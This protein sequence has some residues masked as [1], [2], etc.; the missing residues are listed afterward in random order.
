MFA[1]LSYIGAHWAL[2][3]AVALAVIAL[4]AAS[5]F[6]KNWKL[7]V[8]AFA[9]LA[10]GFVYQAV[11]MQGYKRRV[12]EE[13]AIQVKLL[14][15]RLDTVNAINQAYNARYSEDQKKLS[16]LEKQARETPTNHSPCLDRDAARRVRSIR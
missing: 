5:W 9:V 16:E 14:Q 2:I 7:A 4:G 15:S 3:I 13:A 1:T 12:A 8:A 10:A 6:L 11:D